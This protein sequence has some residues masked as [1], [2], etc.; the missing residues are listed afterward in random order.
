[1]KTQKRT[2][3]WRS[4]LFVLLICCIFSVFTGCNNDENACDHMPSGWIVDIEATLNKTGSKHTECTIC[5]E[6]LETKT[7]PKE[8]CAHTMT[9]WVIDKQATLYIEGSRH[10]ECITCG[11]TLAT[12]V[13]PE[14]FLTQSQI[15]SELR[16]SVVKVV[17]YDYD[18]TTK[19]SQGSGFFID[20]KGTFITNAHV[21]EDCYFV[22]IT[23]YLGSTYEVDV[24]YV[25]SNVVSDYAILKTKNYAFADPVEFEET[26]EAGDTVYAIGF[27]NNSF[28]A[29]TS[30]GEIVHT[31]VVDGM[32]DYY[33]TTAWI[34][35]GSSGGILVNDKGKVLGIT[36]GSFA[37]GT[38]ASLKYTEFKVD[39][40]RTH[41][42]TK[43][44]V[45]YFHTVTEVTLA[46]YNVDTYFDIEVG[47]SSYTDTSVWYTV[48][49]GLNDYWKTQKITMDSFS[50]S[51][52]VQIDTTY[53]F[54]QVLAYSDLLSRRYTYDTVSFTFYNESDLRL[55]K[56]SSV[57]SY[58][59]LIGTDYYGM[60]ITYDADFWLVNGSM[61]IYS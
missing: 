3:L 18:G 33:S 49:I 55:G 58:I 42:G 46:S 30:V 48:K 45:E 25:Y 60:V 13:I 31:N 43:E 50:I 16:D 34:D 22:K 24:M 52:S 2:F 51:I 11:E 19:L 36:T 61:T 10:Q 28:I 20:E 17:C 47:V 41:F 8:T 23:N 53:K 44:P 39:A 6:T 14:L 29:N 4:I 15:T 59:S 9:E 12:E 54:Y 27:P 37:D 21:V 57:F 7:I 1:M 56:N 32:K 35:H 40:N 26:A 38:Y 5:G